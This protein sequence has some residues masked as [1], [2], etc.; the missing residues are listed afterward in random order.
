MTENAADGQAVPA[1]E[2]R[3]AL[4][5]SARVGVVG[6]AAARR[7]LRRYLL[8]I[9]AL[10][11][12]WL[13]VIIAVSAWLETVNS[14][15]RAVTVGGTVGLLAAV[16]LLPAR[17]EPVRA[18]VTGRLWMP[19]VAG[20]AAVF[21]VP[22]AVAADRPALALAGIPFVFGYWAVCAWRWPRER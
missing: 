17:A 16:V 5:L 18:Q 12:G 8:G 13:G 9:G 22:A 14:L 15:W 11:A 21:A 7:Y 3:E 19:V 1:Q 10:L 20:G 2:V 4:A 6:E